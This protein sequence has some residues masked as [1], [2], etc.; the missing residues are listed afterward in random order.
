MAKKDDVELEVESPIAPPRTLRVSSASRIVFPATDITPAITKLE[1]VQYVIAVGEPLLRVLRSRP[2]TLERWPNGV[3]PGMHLG[4]GGDDGGFYQKRMIRHAPDF[5][6]GVEIAFPSGRTAAEVCPT[7]P[8]VLAWCAQMGTITFHPWPVRRT[9]DPS[10]VDKPDELRIDLDPEPGTTFRDVVRVALAAGDL[11]NEFGITGYCKTS[12]GRGVHVFVR[13]KPDWDFIDVRH[14]AIAFGRELERRDKGVTTE[15][16]KELRGERVFVDYNQNC[17]DRTIAAAWS[18]RS[19]AGAP[20]S[21]PVTWTELQQ[22]SDP[23]ELNV[24][25]VP[26]RL[27]EAGDPWQGLDDVHH[28][29]DQLLDLWNENPVEMNF[30]PDYPKM[31]G[32]PPRVQP[33]RKVAANWEDE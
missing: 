26:E 23:R 32:E 8:A 15:W 17:R 16:W 19:R 13:I 24:A 33:S 28:S 22:I 4:R 7:E 21:T 14:A 18:P 11:L 25:T 29:I 5:V 27:A 1:L 3:Q 20:V 10:S 9:E 12:G 6:E 30:P 2:T 31:P